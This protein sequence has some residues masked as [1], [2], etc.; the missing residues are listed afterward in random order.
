MEPALQTFK[1]IG[2]SPYK[3]LPLSGLDESLVLQICRYYLS[4]TREAAGSKFAIYFI[5]LIFF[6]YIGV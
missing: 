4:K 1:V 6:H 2:P 5:V 3:T